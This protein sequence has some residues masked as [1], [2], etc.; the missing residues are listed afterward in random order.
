MNSEMQNVVMLLTPSGLGAIAVVRLSG[1][2]V[3]EFAKKHC[4]KPLHPGRAIHMQLHD[5]G[6]IIDDPVCVLHTDESRLDLNLHGR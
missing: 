2:A 1:P 4:S 5:G 6:R 3:G